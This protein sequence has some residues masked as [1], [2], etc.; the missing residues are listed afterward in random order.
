MY[1]VRYYTRKALL[2][3]Y[4]DLFHEPPLAMFVKKASGVGQVKVYYL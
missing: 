2:L 4:S 3:T 1:D